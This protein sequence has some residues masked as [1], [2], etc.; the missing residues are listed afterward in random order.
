MKP[1]FVFKLNSWVII[2]GVVLALFTSRTDGATTTN[3]NQ[4]A[5]SLAER[6]PELKV[7]DR[8]LLA[9]PKNGFGKDYLFTASLIPQ[10]QAATST[11]LAVSRPCRA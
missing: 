7:A 4:P 10:A 3:T 5:A 9:I 11:G 8:F 2:L 1:H 6:A